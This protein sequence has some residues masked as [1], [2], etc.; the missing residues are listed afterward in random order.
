M[1]ETI[2]SS[3]IMAKI[4]F[5]SRRARVKDKFVAPLGAIL[6]TKR[7]QLQKREN[8]HFE[9]SRGAS[10]ARPS[11]GKWWHRGK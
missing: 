10:A 1:S 5:D 2:R 11:S 4:V 8:D 3:S 9:D 6:S 7:P